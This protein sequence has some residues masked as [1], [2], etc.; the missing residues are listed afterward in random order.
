[1]Q[2]PFSQT[3]ST[4]PLLCTDPRSQG[5]WGGDP[6]SPRAQAYIRMYSPSVLEIYVRQIR[7]FT[8]SQENH[9]KVRTRTKEPRPRR[10]TPALEVDYMVVLVY[11]VLLPDRLY[12]LQQ[13]LP[14]GYPLVRGLRRETVFHNPPHTQGPGYPRAEPRPARIHCLHPDDS[15]PV[16]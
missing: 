1:V 5:M 8:E 10:R 9:S 12:V 13:G 16:G 15:C 6:F 2:G 14:L 3:R 4:R 11:P 7:N